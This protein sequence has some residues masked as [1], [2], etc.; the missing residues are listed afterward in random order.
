MDNIDRWMDKNNIRVNKIKMSKIEGVHSAPKVSVTQK[1]PLAQKQHN[2]NKMRNLP[3]RNFNNKTAYKRPVRI[4][5]QAKFV[6]KD[7][8]A[9]RAVQSAHQQGASSQGANQ[10]TATFQ[11]APSSNFKKGVL[12]VIPLGGL[13][14]V[15]KNMMVFEYEQDIVI[16]DMGFQFPETDMPGIDYI[17]PDVSYLDDKKHRIRGILITHGHMDHIG[18]IAYLIERLNFPPVFATKLTAGFINKQLEEFGLEKRVKLHTFN[19]D[20]ALLRLGRFEASFF[21]VNHSIPDATAIVLKTPIGSIV[22]TGDFKFDESPARDQKPADL[23]RIAQIGAKGILA[24]FSESTNALEPGHTMTETSIGMKIAELI[25]S[26]K[27]RVIIASFSSLIGRIQQILDIAARNN[28]KVFL[29]GRSMV[30]SIEIAS[31]LG[32]IHY[33][34]DL[35]KDIRTVSSVADKDVLI[36][37]TGSQGEDHSSLKRI[38]EKEHQ[39]VKIRPL[40]TVIISANPII[41]NERA[42]VSV[43]NN[44]SKMGAKVIHNRS[45]DV[46][47]SGHG[48]Q[49]DL[50]MMIDLIRPKYLI[51]IH[52]EYF[53]RQAHKM[54]GLEMG[55]KDENIVLIENGD[56]LELTHGRA[57]F[58]N[59]KLSLQHILID[60]F[61]V[62]DIGT[63]ILNERKQMSENGIVMVLLPVN[64]KT[65]KLTGDPD[66]ISRGFVF[67]KNSEKV[68]DELAKT[69]ASAYREITKKRSDLKRGEIKHYIC[70]Q[71]E[72]VA[73]KQLDRKPL[74]LPIII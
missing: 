20:S 64:P 60:G 55:M 54:L 13:N 41:G 30:D 35:I 57:H 53:M 6:Q 36:L 68:V 63:Q 5:Q 59:Q 62:G 44:L 23:Q 2:A 42:V 26:A 16:V 11:K 73:I 7:K 51:P 24:L 65:G 21:R 45:M 38:S 66:I 10:Q 22:H 43:I 34:K 67:L 29:S 27:G 58:T 12:K 33:P 18:G 19:P 48:C 52:G 69:A 28:K 39:Q 46:H 61:G 72:K 1:A 37:T 15:G 74:I 17:I 4:M 71:L 25:E 50:K 8:P 47:V 49:E 14:E 31:K 56:V 70:T 32:Y 3:K 40:D 9:E